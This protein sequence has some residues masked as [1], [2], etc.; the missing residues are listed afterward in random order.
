MSELL[1]SQAAELIQARHIGDDVRFTE[2]SIDSRSLQPGALFVALQG[3][4]FDG[5]DYVGAAR[6]RGAV[7]AMVSRRPQLELPLLQ[8]DDTRLGLGRLA[9]AWRRR[10]GKTLVAITGSNGKTTVKELLAAILGERGAVLA[11]RGNLNND[12]GVPLTLLRLR[13]EPY[14]VI[15]MGAN[16]AGEIGYLSA[17]AR[18]DLVLLNNVGAAHLEGFGSL[19]GVARA[20]GEIIAGLGPDGLVVLNADDPWSDLWRRLAGER[21]VIGFGSGPRA[22]L[23]VRPEEV[24]VRWDDQGFRSVFEVQTPDRVL[25]LELALGGFHNVM[26]ALAASAAALALDTDP[27]QVRAGLARVRP[28]KGRLQTRFGPAGLRVIDDS[29]N[30]N[31][32]SVGAAI[33]LLASAPDER[34]L[35]L[36]DLA[37]LGPE[38]ELLHR[39]LGERAR[40]AGIDRLFTL[41]SAS[42]AASQGFGPGSVHCDEL[43]RLLDSLHNELTGPVCVL[44]KG[45]R[46]ARMERVADAL[47]GEA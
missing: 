11:T 39:R 33:E 7:G 13:D 15:E 16:H 38:A 47:V 4:S 30:A 43:P 31:P 5:H 21:R 1:L 19:E 27:A 24:Q 22:E 44:V 37:E 6:E 35:V 2:V 29:Y 45:S 18:P 26:N 23:R 34:W 17:L 40:A 20:K 9:A 46:A 36:G 10:F 28:V 32:D 14:A 25:D 41:G 3:P 8:A 42:R 12:I